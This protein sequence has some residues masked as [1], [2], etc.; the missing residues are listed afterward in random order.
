MEPPPP[1][2]KRK[3]DSNSEL[4]DSNKLILL[5]GLKLKIGLPSIMDFIL[6]LEY[7]KVAGAYRVKLI[8]SIFTVSSALP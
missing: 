8:R 1:R 2:S 7:S 3:A 6:N 4:V 5:H